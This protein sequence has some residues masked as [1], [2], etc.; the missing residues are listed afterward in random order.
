LARPASRSRSHSLP[1]AIKRKNAG[2]SSRINR[3]WNGY[4]FIAEA[5]IATAIGRTNIA[6]AGRDRRASETTPASTSDN[7]MTTPAHGQIGPTRFK[8]LTKISSRIPAAR[9]R[10]SRESGQIGKNA[11]HQNVYNV[12]SDPSCARDAR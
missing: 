10:L 2:T 12:V 1:A 9:D 11:N 3:P 4:R 8:G 7:G 5:T 6:Q